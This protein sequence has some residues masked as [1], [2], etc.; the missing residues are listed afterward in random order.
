MQRGQAARLR[1]YIRNDDVDGNRP[2]VDALVYKAQELGLVGAIALRGIIGFGRSSGPHPTEL[3][4]AQN[5]PVIVEVVDSR[6][7]IDRYLAAID[8]L[9]R[10]ALVTVEPVEVLRYD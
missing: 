8:P 7:E 5:V 4:L 9:L 1:I 10:G 6:E 3:I 2:L